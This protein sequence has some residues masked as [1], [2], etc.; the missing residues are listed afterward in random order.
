MDKYLTYKDLPICE[1]HFRQVGHVCSVCD[2]VT[3]HVSLPRV[4]RDCR[5]VSWTACAWWT[6]W[7]CAR[8]TTRSWWPPGPASAAARRY[9]Q[10][11]GP[12]F[13]TS[14]PGLFDYVRYWFLGDLDTFKYRVLENCIVI[15]Y[16][17]LW[18][19]VLGTSRYRCCL[20]LERMEWRRVQHEEHKT[21]VMFW[22]RAVTLCHVTRDTR[23][24]ICCII[25][26]L[27]VFL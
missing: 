8:R 12:T 18:C 25:L 17:V 19:I 26:N 21:R 24:L 13:I 10:V 20:N 27:Q 23:P 3:C 2:E 6:A 9:P 5:S 4:T 1:K 22:Q 15:E 7:S 16:C 14:F 11:T